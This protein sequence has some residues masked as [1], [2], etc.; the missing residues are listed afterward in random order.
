MR[1]L[2]ALLALAACSGALAGAA[3]EL[4]QHDGVWLQRGIR[5]YQRLSAHE[6]LPDSDANEAREVSSY[7]CAVVDTHKHLVQRANMLVAALQQGKKRRQHIDAKVLDGM[8]R[9][10]PMIVP[11]MKAGFF[12][13]IPSCERA[14]LI[15]QSFLEKYPEVLDKDADTLV[16]KALLDAYDPGKEP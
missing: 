1:Y 16:E 10:L 15:V 13:D 11:L 2:A 7:V 5:Q 9:S 8:A 4:P 12:A 14:L 6:S 3:D